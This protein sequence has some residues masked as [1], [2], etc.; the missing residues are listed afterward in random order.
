MTDSAPTA[1]AKWLQRNLRGNVQ[2]DLWLL[3][4]CGLV[5]IP[6]ERVDRC[7]TRVAMPVL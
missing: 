7:K 3:Q 5:R 6:K 2:D 4:A 1:V